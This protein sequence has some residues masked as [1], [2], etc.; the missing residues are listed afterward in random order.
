MRVQT[1]NIYPESD[2]FSATIRVQTTT[3]AHLIIVT[4]SSSLAIYSPEA[5]RF[6]GNMHGIISVFS[7]NL[8]AAFQSF[9]CG[10]QALP[11]LASAH[12][13]TSPFPHSSSVT[14]FSLLILQH[15]RQVPASGLYIY[16]PFCIEW[17]FS[18]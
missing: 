12:F 3:I 11:D 18:R 9:I 6:R 13:L 14:F 1:D 15:Q 4:P 17:Y 10:L 8:P 2:H 5:S 16:R 7:L